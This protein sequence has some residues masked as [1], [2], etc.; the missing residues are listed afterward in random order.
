MTTNFEVLPLSQYDP[1]Q[2]III[3]YVDVG[4]M[5]PSRIPSYLEQYKKQLNP[6]FEKRGFEVLYVARRL[7][8][9]SCNIEVDNKEV[10]EKVDLGKVMPTDANETSASVNELIKAIETIEAENNYDRAKIVI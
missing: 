8:R 2:D 9:T 3:V 7:E 5:P 1:N 10:A 4:R 6:I